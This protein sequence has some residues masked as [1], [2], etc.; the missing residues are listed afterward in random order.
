MTPLNHFVGKYGILF[1]EVRKERNMFLD[2]NS[3]M[4]GILVTVMTVVMVL[5]LPWLDRH[6][7]SRLGVSIS[8][9]IS[10]NPNAEKLLRLRRA[11]LILA[12]GVYLLLV[13]YVTFFSRSAMDDYK[14]H[15]ALFQD[16]ANSIK[17]DYGIFTIIRIFFTEGLSAVL[18]H[19]QIVSKYNVSQVLL[20]VAMFIPLGYLLPYIFDWYRRS[21]R[22]RVVITGFLASLLIENVQLVTKHGYYD[23]DDLFSNTIGAWIGQGLYVLFAYVNTHPEWRKDFRNYRKWRAKYWKK[24]LAQFY[25]K[26]HLIRS[27]VFCSDEN[28]AL[29]FFVDKLGFL[30][31]TKEID[32]DTGTESLLLEFNGTQIEVECGHDTSLSRVQ[33]ITIAANN[34]ER[35]RKRLE[36]AGITVSDYKLDVYTG[37]RTFSI[38]AT[39]N[40]RIVF[41]EE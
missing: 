39:D 9:G 7:C 19:I 8:D 20:N 25:G 41:I 26:M 15:V 3:D 13:A 33:T 36:K 34:S 21:I 27:T 11:I 16:L 32:P 29:D 37:L 22:R 31:R 5:L 28:A 17:I 40:I 1:R 23:I 6:I 12:F 24:P 30:L 18:S 2:P 35:I 14:V 10:T 38:D 4:T